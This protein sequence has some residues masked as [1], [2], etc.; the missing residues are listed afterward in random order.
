EE[1]RA[2]QGDWRL[3]LRGLQGRQPHRAHGDRSAEAVLRLPPDA[4]EK[5]LRLLRLPPIEANRPRAAL[6]SGTFA[7]PASPAAARHSP[8]Y[9]AALS[10]FRPDPRRSLGSP[11]SRVG[12]IKT[13]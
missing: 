3:G 9:R 6:V 4:A 5:R 2:V 11:K 1:P 8:V 10:P 13:R 12:E 7:A